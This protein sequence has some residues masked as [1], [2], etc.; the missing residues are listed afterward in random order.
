MNMLLQVMIIHSELL[1]MQKPAMKDQPTIFNMVLEVTNYNEVNFIQPDLIKPY[2][3]ESG[4]YK[5]YTAERAPH[6]VFT[7]K[8]KN[9]SNKIVGDEKNPYL[10]AK[11]IFTWISTKYS[12][13]WCKRI[14]NN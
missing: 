10:I 4:L 9:L 8:I 1:Y 11:K 6:I 2:N 12:L 5:T 13:G 14:F 7:D 3:K